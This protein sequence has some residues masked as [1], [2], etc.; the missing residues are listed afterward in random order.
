MKRMR[1]KTQRNKATKRLRLPTLRTDELG[2]GLGVAA[3][4]TSVSRVCLSFGS[5]ED[6]CE[7]PRFVLRRVDTAGV[8]LSYT[9]LVN[10][11]VTVS[12]LFFFCA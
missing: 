8:T 12:S 5:S 11:G 7:S 6:D 2:T 4:S 10:I 3:G 1:M 9:M